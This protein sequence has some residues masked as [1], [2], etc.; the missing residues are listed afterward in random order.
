MNL[1]KK[2]G[3]AL[4]IIGISL[5]GSAMA[6]LHLYGF[7]DFNSANGLNITTSSGDFFV[8]ITD[9]GWWTNSFGHDASK[10]ITL[11]ARALIAR[12]LII[13]ITF[14]LLTLLISTAP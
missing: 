12:R 7:S 5:P 9:S 11:L 13:L 8:P 4:S 1:R 14:S 6:D 3:C 2:L 10:K